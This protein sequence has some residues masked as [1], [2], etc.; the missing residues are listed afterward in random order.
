MVEGLEDDSLV[1]LPQDCLG[2]GANLGVG[3]LCI[4]FSKTE[5]QGRGS[6]AA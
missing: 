1:W 2:A 4:V 3:R 5:R 6:R